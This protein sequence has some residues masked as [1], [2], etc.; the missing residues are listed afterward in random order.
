M[1]KLTAAHKLYAA[2]KII[3][4]AR[5]QLAVLF[6][7]QIWSARKKSLNTPVLWFHLLPTSAALLLKCVTRRGR[8]C[9]KMRDV[10]YGRPL[11]QLSSIRVKTV[12]INLVKVVTIPDALQSIPILLAIR[13]C[14][15]APCQQV[16]NFPFS[17]R[18]QILTPSRMQTRWIPEMRKEKNEFEFTLFVENFLNWMQ[19]MIGN[20]TFLQFT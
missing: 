14:C 6:Y 12:M 2:I 3:F 4:A 9:Q 8:E 13:I 5:V 19:Q 17:G 18:G 7:F 20:F 11:N 1:A 15:C 16:W 10:I